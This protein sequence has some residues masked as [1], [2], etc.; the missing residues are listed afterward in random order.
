[1]KSYQ[2]AKDGHLLSTLNALG[3]ASSGLTN[4]IKVARK[5]KTQMEAG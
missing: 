3:E 5:V 1:M 2:Q 4:R